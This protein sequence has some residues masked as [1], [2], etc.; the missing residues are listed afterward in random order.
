MPS[1]ASG[2]S[3]AGQISRKIATY[4]ALQRDDLA[5]EEPGCRRLRGHQTAADGP[6]LADGHVVGRGHVVEAEEVVV[7]DAFDVAGQARHAGPDQ[8]IEVV[9]AA[10]SAAGSPTHR[11]HRGWRCSGHGGWTIFWNGDWSG[12]NC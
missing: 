12:F 7:V 6:G 8:V 4:R 9:S 2:V 5:S 3:T 1:P 11:D 10:G